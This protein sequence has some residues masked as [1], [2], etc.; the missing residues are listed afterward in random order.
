ENIYSRFDNQ[1]TQISEMQQPIEENVALRSSFDQTKKQQDEAHE[2]IRQLE[3]QPTQ[4]PLNAA[5]TENTQSPPPADSA[6]KFA[7]Q[8][9]K[10]ATNSKS[11]TSA[12]K[13]LPPSNLEVNDAGLAAARQFTTVSAN[14]GYQFVYITN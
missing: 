8:A 3:T 9:K 6:P 4:Q 11:K 13:K 2:R 7:D 14:H 10:P 1:A 12:R 5:T